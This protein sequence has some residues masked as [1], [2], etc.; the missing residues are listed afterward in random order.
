MTAGRRLIDD[1][2]RCGLDRRG[3]L[4]DHRC[5]CGLDDGGRCGL[6][7]AGRWGRLIDD[8]CR[9]RGSMTGAGAGS[10]GAGV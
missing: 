6:D 2:G 9:V 10:T 3:R 4:I 5:R 8:R 1:G 7:D